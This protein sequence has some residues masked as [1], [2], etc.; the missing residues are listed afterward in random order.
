MKKERIKNKI[1]IDFLIKSSNIN[2]EEKQTKI[3]KTMYEI[4]T[5]THLENIFNEIEPHT[6]VKKICVKLKHKLIFQFY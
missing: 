4:D 2:I 3:E 6:D 1:N 5:Q